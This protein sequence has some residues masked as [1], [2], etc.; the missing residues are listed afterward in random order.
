FL[1][2]IEQARH[3]LLGHGVIRGLL[4]DPGRVQLL[5]QQRDGHLQLFRELGD[6]R[7]CHSYAFLV[8]Q[9]CE[10]SLNHGSR[11]FMISLLARS[12]SIPVISVS[13]SVARSASASIVV[14]PFEARTRAVWL[15]MPSMPCKSSAACSSVSSPLMFSM[16]SALRARRRSSFTVSSS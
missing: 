12:T 1:Q 11:A 6:V 7:L 10:P 3:V 2:V 13:S 4:L 15:S 16:R 5:E 9:A 14:M 8:P